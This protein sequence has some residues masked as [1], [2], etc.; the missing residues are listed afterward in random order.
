MTF[1]ADVDVDEDS[2]L[3]GEPDAEPFELVSPPVLS[4][5]ET[6]SLVGSSGVWRP[7]L[8]TYSVLLLFSIDDVLVIMLIISEAK[9]HSTS[10]GN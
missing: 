10:V 3:D 4:E 7:T 5:K 2:D 1:S 9:L 8:S 6:D